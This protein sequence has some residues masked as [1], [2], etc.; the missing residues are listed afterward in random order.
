MS[1]VELGRPEFS[2]IDFETREVLDL[3][4]KYIMLAGLWL[5]ILVV[6]VRWK[7]KLKALI[8]P[9]VISLTLFVVMIKSQ[10]VLPDEDSE[11]TENGYQHRIEI[12]K[13]ETGTKV[14]HWKSRD[15]VKNY[16]SYR[17]IEWILVEE[18]EIKN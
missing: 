8:I 9:T 3:I 2:T 5:P 15:S 18:E 14:K 6:I 17:H 13:Q 1:F 10:D 7:R 16:W 11:Y 4:L 12:W